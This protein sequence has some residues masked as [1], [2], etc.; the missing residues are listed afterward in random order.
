MDSSA[1]RPSYS[2]HI[3]NNS[4][5]DDDKPTLRQPQQHHLPSRK[6]TNAHLSNNDNKASTLRQ[7]DQ[8]HLPIGSKTTTNTI[9]NHPHPFPQPLHPPPTKPLP[10]PP[11]PPRNPSRLHRHQNSSL[12]RHESSSLLSRALATTSTTTI[13][14]EQTL[15]ATSRS[16]T[17]TH[18]SAPVL[19]PPPP[20]TATATAT[21]SIP[22][23]ETLREEILALRQ[24][25]IASQLASADSAPGTARAPPPPPPPPPQRRERD[26]SVP[27]AGS[28][29]RPQT[30]PQSQRGRILRPARPKSLDLGSDLVRAG[31]GAGAGAGAGAKRK[32]EDQGWQTVRTTEAGEVFLGVDVGATLRNEALLRGERREREV[33][34]RG[35]VVREEEEQGEEGGKC[36]LCGRGRRALA[37]NPACCAQR[38]R[39]VCVECWGEALGLGVGEGC[40]VC[41]GQL[42]REDARR[43]GGGGRGLLGR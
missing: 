11:I 39:R 2:T 22:F 21:A 41:G 18:S 1:F 6:Q 32:D 5:N 14:G 26:F 7:P 3:N 36:A 25:Y 34:K 12:L 30:Q 37:R 24:S 35:V 9:T 4:N 13:E 16:L 28:P 42:G 19:P 29:T 43:L 33:K 10:A 8:N 23:R 31:V 38:R 17:R 20:N 40:V 27:S 15:P